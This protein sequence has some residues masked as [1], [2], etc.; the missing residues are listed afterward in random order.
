MRFSSLT[1]NFE[2]NI[3]FQLENVMDLLSNEGF[4]GG[5]EGKESAAMRE[6]GFDLWVGKIPQRRECLPTA[7]FLPG[8][9]QG[10]RSLVGCS[11]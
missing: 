8:E 1:Q 10:Q 5:S 9:C 2:G 11:P 7:A 4:P 3:F 6:M